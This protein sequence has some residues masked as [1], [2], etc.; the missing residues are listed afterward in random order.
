MD[1]SSLYHLTLASD[2]DAAVAAGTYTGS[3]LGRTLAEE[4]FIHLSRHEQ[5]AGTADRFYRGRHD[6]VLVT[7]DPCRLGAPVVEDPVGDDR[8]P[9]LYGPL[10]PAAALEVTPLPLGPD[11]ILVL[12]DAFR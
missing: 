6:V 10:D 5:V 8:Y 3:T 11:G 1:P 7:L 12:P 2:W 9:H 4:G